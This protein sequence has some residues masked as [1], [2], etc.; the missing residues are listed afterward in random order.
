MARGIRLAPFCPILEIFLDASGAAVPFTAFICGDKTADN[1]FCCQDL[2]LGLTSMG[3]RRE[4]QVVQ[5]ESG[6]PREAHPAHPGSP[7]LP[8]PP[9]P[10]SKWPGPPACPSTLGSPKLPQASQGRTEIGDICL[11]GPLAPAPAHSPQSFCRSLQSREQQRVLPSLSERRPAVSPHPRTAPPTPARALR[12]PD[13]PW[14]WRLARDSVHCRPLLRGTVFS[15][16]PSPT[17]RSRGE[18]EAA[19][20]PAP[21]RRLRLWYVCGR[22][23]ASRLR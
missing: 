3:Y 12:E 2:G 9:A 1:F 13:T 6:D 17:P 18:T 5:G 8:L 15:D 21:G 7:E 11:S 23:P 14:F 16:I 4:V 19:G 22:G 10:A 20:H